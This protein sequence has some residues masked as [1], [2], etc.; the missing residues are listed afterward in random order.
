MLSFQV[1]D[2]GGGVLARLGHGQYF[3][4]RALL[5][6]EVRA[7]DV[8]VSGSAG[9]LWVESC[10]QARRP[11]KAALLRHTS[12]SRVKVRHSKHLPP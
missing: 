7:A 9:C 8:V 1:K 6:G 5:G 10:D 3:G 11:M 2:A 4:E 12:P